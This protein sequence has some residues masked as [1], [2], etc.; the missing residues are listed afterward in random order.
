MLDA[1]AAAPAEDAARRAELAAEAR[2]AIL[3][4]PIPD[5]VAAAVPRAYAARGE[6]GEA[7]PVAVRCG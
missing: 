4:A 2:A 1:L 3:A 6:V 7:V 5:A